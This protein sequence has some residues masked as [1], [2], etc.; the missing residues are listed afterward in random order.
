M[1][2]FQRMEEEDKEVRGRLINGVENLNGQE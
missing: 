1:D 2:K